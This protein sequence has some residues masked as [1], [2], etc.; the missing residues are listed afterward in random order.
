MLAS[1][2]ALKIKGEG[3]ICPPKIQ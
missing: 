3:E 2:L 1:I